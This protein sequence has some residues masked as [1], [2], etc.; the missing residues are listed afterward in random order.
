MSK[1]EG[2][3]PALVGNA[4]LVPSG[5]VTLIELSEKGWTILRP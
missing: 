5:A 2:K 4:E 3:A 1:R